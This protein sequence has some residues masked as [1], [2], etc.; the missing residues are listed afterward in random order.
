MGVFMGAFL[1][2]GGW[3]KRGG[4]FCAVFA[5]WLSRVGDASDGNGGG[6]DFNPDVCIFV[7]SDPST[8]LLIRITRLF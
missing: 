7:L 8:L 6:D 3:L 4:E 5:V 2:W 1:G